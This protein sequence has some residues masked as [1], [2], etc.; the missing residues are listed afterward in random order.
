VQR[1]DHETLFKLAVGSSAPGR[2][3]TLAGYCIEATL[4]A[5]DK[6]DICDLA[7]DQ[8]DCEGDE[9]VRSVVVSTA[10]KLMLRLGESGF[11]RAYLTIGDLFRNGIGLPEDLGKAEYWYG[12]AAFV[13]SF[14]A[15]KLASR[16]AAA[17]QELLQS[18]EMN[19]QSE[20]GIRMAEFYRIQMDL[21]DQFS[22]RVKA[23]T[24]DQIIDCLIGKGE[25][26]RVEFKVTLRWDIK[27]QIVASYLED[28][29]IQELAA[30]MNTEAGTLLIGVTNDKKVC[31][32][33]LDYQSFTKDKNRDIFDRHL[34]QILRNAFGAKKDL[35][36]IVLIEFSEKDICQIIVRRS[37]EA[38]FIA[39]DEGRKLWIRD[40][41]SKR[42]LTGEELEEFLRKHP[43]EK[44]A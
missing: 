39:G 27:K 26:G 12:M 17:Y 16:T 33:E 19:D 8:L 22:K 1:Q 7:L 44:G 41:P 23:M 10:A 43:T 37:Q 11:Q 32:L 6:Q 5:G 25:I 24:P 29:V 38:V 4:A 21:A 2:P 3:L 9:P 13:S 18:T 15:S 35:C 30:F 31:G 42:A 20:T 40:G 28:G 14:E 34:R 36:S